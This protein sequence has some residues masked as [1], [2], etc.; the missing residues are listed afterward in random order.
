MKRCMNKR[1]W[2]A[3]AASMMGTLPLISHAAYDCTVS[4]NSLNVRYTQGT[5][6]NTSGQV[7]ITCTRLSTDSATNTYSVGIDQGEPPAGRQYTRIG[8]TQTLNYN[9]YRESTYASTWN[10]SNRR[11]NGN[12]NFGTGLITSFNVPYY[13]RITSQTGKPAGT[14]DD[15]LVSFIVRI[16]QTNPI[17]GQ[18]PIAFYA[19][20][21]PVCAISTPPG[22]INLSYQAFSASPVNATTNFSVNCT[23]QTPYTMSL[24][25][26]SGTIAGILYNL[27]L[28]ATSVNATGAP[29]AHSITATAPANQAGTCATG[30]C[31]GTQ[32]HTLTIT[33]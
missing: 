1:S 28:S 26:N 14:Y 30:T 23:N 8:G 31:T 24:S 27:S 15:T 20:I 13:L 19:V 3:L 16:P 21:D 25:A 6:L 22:N 12:I 2:V 11:V 7:T 10:N 32:A 33:Y 5:V 18:D 29:Q 4:G 17:V 9:I